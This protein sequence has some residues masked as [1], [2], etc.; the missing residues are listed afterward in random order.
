[1]GAIER[2]LATARGLAS[3]AGDE[4][5]LDEAYADLARLRK[6]ETAAKLACGLLYE[7]PEDAK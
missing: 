5:A 4:A 1:M 6:T 2:E 7:Y 3:S